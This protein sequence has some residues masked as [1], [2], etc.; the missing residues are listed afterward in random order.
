M[1]EAS[2]RLA[3]TASGADTHVGLR[4][5]P[6]TTPS[7]KPTTTSRTRRAGRRSSSSAA[8]CG[9]APIRA[10][11]TS[12]AA[13]AARRSC[14]HRRTAAT[15]SASRRRR[16]SSAA[17]RER[18]EA[19]GLSHL[20]EVV[21]GDARAFPLEPEAW[22]VALCLGASFAFDDLDGT[23]AALAPAVRSGGFVGVGEPYWREWP[24][25]REVDDMGYVPLRETVARIEAGGLAL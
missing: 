21:E 9:S 20:I 13:S 3:A 25:P 15:S 6:G 4:E 1:T 17:A 2:P 10:S 11:S 24:L 16:S 12:P 8:T 22:D 14:S 23:V 19:A 5:C 7:P 18:V